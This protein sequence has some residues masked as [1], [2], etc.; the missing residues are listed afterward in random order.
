MSKDRADANAQA[1]LNLQRSYGCCC[2]C[3]SIRV[4]MW[5]FCVFDFIIILGSLKEFPK[6]DEDVP[7]LRLFIKCYVCGVVIP[8][9]FVWLYALLGKTAL[10][11]RVLCRFITYKIPAFVLVYGFFFVFPAPEYALNSH[12]Y[13]D[14][15][16]AVH[17]T[18]EHIAATHAIVGS[19]VEECAARV[20]YFIMF[21]CCYYTL[22]FSFSFKA[23]KQ[24]MLC[25]PDNEGQGVWCRDPGTRFKPMIDE[26]SV[27]TA[28]N[29]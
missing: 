4:E 28:L 21:R 2:K 25:H 24:Y 13:C 8:S 17:G 15:N 11:R 19:N 18:P 14:P 7:M 9:F 27:Y 29:A 6:P 5:C 10:A 1:E 22:A 16:A 20:R 26:P 23:A 3:C 12:Y